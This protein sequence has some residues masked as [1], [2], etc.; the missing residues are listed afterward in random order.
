MPTLSN[1]LE[2]IKAKIARYGGDAHCNPIFVSE[3]I[4][5]EA[6]ANRPDSTGRRKTRIALELYSPESYTAWNE[7]LES[8]IERC[9]YNPLI[10][11]DLLR[12]LVM[13]AQQPSFQEGKDGIALAL[14]SLYKL[15]PEYESE[16]RQAKAEKRNRNKKS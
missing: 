14:E 4:R 16:L 6:I 11:V 8:L 5:A 15:N 13:E 7:M 1:A 9:G 3:Q 10:L 2:T 12:L